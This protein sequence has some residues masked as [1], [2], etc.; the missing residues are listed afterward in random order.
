MDQRESAPAISCTLFCTEPY[1][2]KLGVTGHRKLDHPEL[3]RRAIEQ[4]LSELDGRLSTIPHRYEILSPLADGSDRLVASCV[5]SWRGQPGGQ[6]ACAGELEAALPMPIEEYIATFDSEQRE[7]SELDFR[8]LL[9]QADR[10]IVLP[11][12]ASHKDAY[13]QV[14]RYVVQECDVLI[15]I[16][17]GKTSRGRGGTAEIVEFAQKSCRS[18]FCIDPASGAVKLF[19]TPRGFINQIDAFRRYN[20]ERPNKSERQ[21]SKEVERRAHKLRAAWKAQGLDTAVLAPLELSVLPHSIKAG[22]L[23][24]KYQSRY[25]HSILLA[26]ALSAAAVFCAALG[27]LVLRRVGWFFAESGLI[28]LATVLAWPSLFEKWQRRW[29]D[30]RYFAERLRC[31]Y[32]LYLGGLQE[33]FSASWPDLEVSSIPESWTDVAIRDVW[34]HIPDLKLSE[35]ST[36][37]AETQAKVSVFLRETWIDAQRGY[38]D[39][40]AQRNYRAR[41]RFEVAIKTIVAVTLLAAISHA[42]I[43]IRWHKLEDRHPGVPESL[44]LL[45]VTLPALAS[46]L[47]GISV[48]RNFSRNAERYESMSRHLESISQRMLT[49]VP[50]DGSV[51]KAPS[52]GNPATPLQK[53]LREAD[54]AMT[55]EHRSWRSVFGIRLPGP[56]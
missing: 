27:A 52:E 40:A 35:D 37:S 22:R 56:G 24:Q 50:A 10:I 41:E 1:K 30:Y 15:A 20:L 43:P 36:F 31:S 44:S 18:T 55:H 23:A 7:K 32:F 5:L 29:I 8:N 12:T 49:G 45:A 2:I 19:T 34:R 51:T 13:R 48:F 9:T 53:L 16:W 46:V 25:F 33:D 6:V 14:G 38:Y 21:F 17:D 42:L 39:R 28:V 54:R 47:A 3:V 4:V 26:Y 11:Q